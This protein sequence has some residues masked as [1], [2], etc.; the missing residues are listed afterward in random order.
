MASTTAVGNCQQGFLRE[1]AFECLPRLT[2][3]LFRRV[4]LSLYSAYY[5]LAMGN[6]DSRTLDA[7]F[8]MT[9]VD[10]EL[11]MMGMQDVI[12]VMASDLV[13]RP[14]TVEYADMNIEYGNYKTPDH[15]IDAVAYIVPNTYNDIATFLRRPRTL[16]RLPLVIIGHSGDPV[17]TNLNPAYP[18]LFLVLKKIAGCR[19]EHGVIAISNNMA[20]ATDYKCLSFN[21]IMF[22]ANAEEN[23]DLF[24]VLEGAEKDKDELEAIRF[25]FD[26]IDLFGHPDASLD[27]SDDN[28][29]SR[30]ET[31]F[32]KKFPSLRWALR[33]QTTAFGYNPYRLPATV[34]MMMLSGQVAHL[35]IQMVLLWHDKKWNEKLGRVGT[36][37]QFMAAFV[38]FCFPPL[39]AR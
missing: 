4:A 37:L 28:E 3:T 17:Y 32:A 31:W 6:A 10:Y 36:I 19:V 39:I 23:N 27:S 9:H 5:S 16:F 20:S 21:G 34:Y 14:G 38:L 22:H 7:D 33:A 12:D 35:I 24:E 26:Y 25:R 15:P 18:A 30:N 29:S 13:F 11:K 2:D 8:N 1:G